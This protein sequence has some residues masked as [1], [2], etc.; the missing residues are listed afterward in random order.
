MEQALVVPLAIAYELTA[1][2]DKVKGYKTNL[3]GK[4][5]YEFL[6]MG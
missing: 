3:L 1:M 4:A 5:K 6:S 2:S